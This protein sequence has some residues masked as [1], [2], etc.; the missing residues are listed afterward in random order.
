[1]EVDRDFDQKRSK[2]TQYVYVHPWQTL[3][4]QFKHMESLY[5]IVLMH[6]MCY[7]FI[8]LRNLLLFF[9]ISTLRSCSIIM[10]VRII[11]HI[12]WSYSDL[13]IVQS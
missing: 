5:N 13:S 11:E 3:W 12:K 4:K 6:F 8:T 7:S 10:K 9:E 1:M 2:H